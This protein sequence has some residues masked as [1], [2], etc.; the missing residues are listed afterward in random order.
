LQVN[1]GV[2]DRPGWVPLKDF[3]CTN[4]DPNFLVS[5]NNF[6]PPPAV[7]PLPDETMTSTPAELTAT[8][9]PSPVPSSP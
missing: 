9:T 6:P 7:T 1:I 8:F 3:A 5:T 2:E 4:F